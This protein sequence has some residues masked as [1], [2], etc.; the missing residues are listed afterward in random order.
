M[1]PTTEAELRRFLGAY[2]NWLELPKH[3]Q[4]KRVAESQELF[5]QH[6]YPAPRHLTWVFADIHQ[7]WEDW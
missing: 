3:W 4:M 5:Q 2:G 1:T 7:V 6:F